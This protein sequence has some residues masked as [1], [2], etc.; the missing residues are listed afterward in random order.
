M[1]FLIALILAFALAALCSKALK[2]HPYIFYFAAVILTVFTVLYSG[3]N[4]RSVPAF[5]NTYIAGLF[6][7]GAF[8][9]ALWCV[10]MWTG[11]M[12]NGSAVIKK[13]MP[14]RGEL[15]ILAAIL[16]LGHN[17]GFGRTY[18]VRLFT[19]AGKMNTSQIVASVL[20]IVMLIIMIPLT[21]MSFPQVRR[22]MN[23]KLWKKIQR[24]AYIFYGLIYIHVMVLTVPMARAGREGY[25]FSIILY[26]IVFLGYA[27]C[28]IRKWYIVRKKTGKMTNPVCAV[29]F[30]ALIAAVANSSKKE[31]SS[32]IPV[33]NNKPV[34]V[35]VVSS[36][37]TESE[38]TTLI[39]TVAATSTSS[40]TFVSTEAATEISVTS[41]VTETEEITVAVS[42]ETNQNEETADSPAQEEQHEE[43]E[44][45]DVPVQE[46][47]P[48]EPV[49][50]YKNGTYSA[51]AYGYDGEIHVSVTI[52]NDVITSITGYSDESDTWYYESAQGSV[53][54]QIIASQST[55]VDA[56]SGA[57][58]S[59]NAIMSAVQ[60]AL[61]SARN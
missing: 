38:V 53:I 22:K 47:E 12:P 43:P 36:P 21:V 40:V 42:E 13:F 44:I 48:Q 10:V 23:A 52:E 17:I 57:T 49:Y 28:R 50:I 60:S 54:S 9:T 55:S 41:G 19:D 3:S 15:S 58:Y 27:V 25:F 8:A 29:I 1:V 61:D 56:Y 20:T 30:A 7:R 16:T 37:V 39:T 4:L 5:V 24:T 26:S 6:T 11:A 35:T 59:S 51:S 31:V 32:A 33:N 18:F 14:V 34:P 45:N 46:E 2:K